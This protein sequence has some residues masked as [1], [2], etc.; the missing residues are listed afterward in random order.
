MKRRRCWSHLCPSGG[1]G[2]TSFSPTTPLKLQNGCREVV[3]CSRSAIGRIRVHGMNRIV[4]PRRREIE[5]YV[6]KLYFNRLPLTINPVP[7]APE[8]LRH[9]FLICC[10]ITRYLTPYISGCYSMSTGLIVR[11]QALSAA[12]HLATYYRLSKCLPNRCCIHAP[13]R[14]L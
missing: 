4:Y 9:L 11:A 8:D 1:L 7:R 6:S 5:Y 13:L 14:L 2:P 10:F 3:M 12:L